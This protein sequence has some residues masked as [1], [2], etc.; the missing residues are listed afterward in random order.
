VLTRIVEGVLVHE[1]EFC[2]SNT[3]ILEGRAGVLLVDPGI[4][5]RELAAIADALRAAGQA[6]AVGFATHPHWDHILWHPELGTAPRFGTAACAET[7]R[8]RLPDAAS[9]AGVTRFM[10]PEI[11]D[12]VPLAQLGDI[13]GLAVDAE[14]MPWEGPEARI[15]VHRAHAPGHA[16]LLMPEHGVLVAGDML[17]DVLVPMLDLGADDPVGDYLEALSLFE[18]VAHE[19]EFVIPGHGSVGAGDAMNSRIARDREYVRALSA[20]ERPDDPRLGADATFPWVTGV[21]ER[22]AQALAE[23][24]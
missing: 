7:I 8:T 1:S 6:V 16:A 20:G 12:D 5:E 2:R 15:V 11:A 14:R 19:V 9:K 17:S 24:P 13:E 22:Q 10:P 4:L 18:S 21:H 3:V 23:R